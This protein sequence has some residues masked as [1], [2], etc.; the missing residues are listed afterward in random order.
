M[1]K[2]KVQRLRALGG[3]GVTAREIAAVHESL[4]AGE[5]LCTTI[6]EWVIKKAAGTGSCEAGEA[7]L[8]GIFTLAEL[9]FFPEAEAVLAPIEAVVLA[10]WG[11]TCAEVGISALGQQADKWA[12]VWC[13]RM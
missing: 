10:E 12:A 6:C 11:G 7:A 4:T 9:L 13:S 5:R 2:V 1:N 3:L 8:S